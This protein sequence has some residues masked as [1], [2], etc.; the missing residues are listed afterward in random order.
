MMYTPYSVQVNR[1][2]AV[3]DI[4]KG[5]VVAN[6]EVLLHIISNCGNNSAVQLAEAWRSSQ[7]SPL[8]QLPWY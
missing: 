6:E 7:S 3:V 8:Q 2:G 1:L 5:P 4:L